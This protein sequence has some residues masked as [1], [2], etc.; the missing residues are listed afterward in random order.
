MKSSWKYYIS[1]LENRDLYFLENE[2]VVSRL[3][4]I[5]RFCQYAEKIYEI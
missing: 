1:L 2:L 5:D 4:D 3:D